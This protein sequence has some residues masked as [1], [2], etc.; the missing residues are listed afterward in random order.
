MQRLANSV[1]VLFYAALIQI[2]MLLMYHFYPVIPEVFLF[3]MFVPLALWF[4]LTELNKV[5]GVRFWV[6]SFAV[7]IFPAIYSAIWFSVTDTFTFLVVAAPT[8]YAI[9][10]AGF[11]IDAMLR[12]LSQHASTDLIE[13]ATSLVMQ[14]TYRIVAKTE[15]EELELFE[16]WDRL[17]E[18]AAVDT[19][20]KLIAA[21]ENVP[22]ILEQVCFAVESILFK[23]FIGN[24]TE[25]LRSLRFSSFATALLITLGYI[26]SLFGVIP[27]FSTLAWANPMGVI[28]ILVVYLAISWIVTV[29]FL[30]ELAIQIDWMSSR[31]LYLEKLKE[32]IDITMMSYEQALNMDLIPKH[33][34]GTNA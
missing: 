33:W 25:R 12:E 21:R 1:E 14:M 18:R 31:L 9:F 29:Y 3:L 19:P 16:K 24:D 17:K 23:R 11:T 32:G 34:Q 2:Y 28:L 10:I 26:A 7:Y 4:R 27:I 5:K 8:L 20:L 15:Y 22:K 13:N 30:L 6:V